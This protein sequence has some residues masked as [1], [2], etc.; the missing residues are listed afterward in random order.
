M[1]K[2][3][4]RNQCLIG[5]MRLLVV[6]LGVWALTCMV[7][8]KITLA[9]TEDDSL[10]RIAFS[11][12]TIGPVNEN[13]AIAAI[14]IWA[15]TLA[16][17]KNITVVLQS[18]IY[19]NSADI[20]KDL[21]LGKVDY[22]SVTT[23]EYFTLQNLMSKD[24]I[25]VSVVDGSISEE[26]V[27]LV[28]RKKDFAKLADLRGGHLRW[29]GSIRNSLALIWLDTVLAG[30]GFNASA[31]FFE[32]ISKKDKVSEVLLPVFFGK[33]DACIVTKSAFELMV[34]LNPQI[35]TQ[36]RVLATSPPFVPSLFGFRAD[37]AS[38]VKEQVMHEL[39]GL[40]MTQASK[41]I[42]TMFKTDSLEK[43]TVSC[44]GDTLSLL[45]EHKRLF[46]SIESK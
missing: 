16:K 41:Q 11:R 31:E 25:I 21:S 30:R 19:K 33:V 6:V 26:Y 14:R 27:V 3:L 42:L 18:K 36:M 7:F 44:L 45:K 39:F 43:Q 5:F 38:P 20:K 28:N 35:G 12:S 40:D 23:P 29:E 32:T 2:I 10:F 15:Q 17:E 24:Q 1:S 46:G 4:L 22:I 9:D 34:E 37:F 8:A 13:D